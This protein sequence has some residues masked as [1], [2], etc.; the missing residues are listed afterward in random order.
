MIRIA[1]GVLLLLVG[2]TSLLEG[3]CV[4][5]S[6]HAVG[7]VSGAM[8]G[9]VVHMQRAIESKNIKPKD[10]KKVEPQQIRDLESAAGKLES[11][12]SGITMASVIIRLGGLLCVISGILFF[13]NRAKLLGFI[14]PGIGIVGE[15]V[16]F[17]VLSFNVFGL[18]K[19]LMYGFGAFAA[20]KLN[21]EV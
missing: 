16:L 8:D 9:A 5:I 4:A 1:G 10:L 2:L 20:T 3:G 18:L 13:L 7:A 17:V 6:C 19:I 15:L 11:R 21:R 14:A 12:K